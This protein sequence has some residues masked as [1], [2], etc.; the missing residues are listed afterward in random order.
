[1]RNTTIYVCAVAQDQGS[2]TCHMCTRDTVNARCCL[3]NCHPHAVS[4]TNTSSHTLWTPTESKTLYKSHSVPATYCTV[5]TCQTVLEH[6]GILWVRWVTC[7]QR[8]R[9]RGQYNTVFEGSQCS[10]CVCVWIETQ[11]GHEYGYLTFTTC[12]QVWAKQTLGHLLDSLYFQFPIWATYM[13]RPL[14]QCQFMWLVHAQSI[15]NDI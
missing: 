9:Q 2:H 11:Q 10:V 7:G 3:H 4:C 8:Q 15:S 13:P 1:M 12:H 6:E 14:T 5:D